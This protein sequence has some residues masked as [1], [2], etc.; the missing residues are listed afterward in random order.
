MALSKSRHLKLLG[1]KWLLSQKRRLFGDT[2]ELFS[3]EDAS[4][5]LVLIFVELSLELHVKEVLVCSLRLLARV[6]PC[7]VQLH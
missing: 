5:A 2:S 3:Q 1:F 4:V 7:S 6:L